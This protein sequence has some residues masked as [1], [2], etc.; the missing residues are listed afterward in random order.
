MSLLQLGLAITAVTGIL[1]LF[2]D[3]IDSV[4]PGF[5]KGYE[6][7]LSP[8]KNIGEKLFGDL[9]DNVTSAFKNGFDLLF[10]SEEDSI[11]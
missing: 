4:I 8:F 6:K 9:I 11:K 2:R 5:K 1:Y 10:G 7:V 3:E